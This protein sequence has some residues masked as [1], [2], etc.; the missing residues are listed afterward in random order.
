MLYTLTLREKRYSYYS[1]HIHQLLGPSAV[2]ICICNSKKSKNR[3]K[4]IN[5]RVKLFSPIK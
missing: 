4:S 5:A 3:G 1:S 2:G